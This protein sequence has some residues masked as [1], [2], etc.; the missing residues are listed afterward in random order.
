MTDILAG[1]KY[2]SR[3]FSDDQ[4][5]IHLSLPLLDLCNGEYY[6]WKCL[7]YLVDVSNEEHLGEMA[8][9]RSVWGPWIRPRRQGYKKLEF[10]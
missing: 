4:T 1:G 8:A 7:K 6:N 3:A 2:S 10:C 5:V 9:V